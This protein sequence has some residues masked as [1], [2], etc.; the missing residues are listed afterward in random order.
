MLLPTRDQ[1]IH[2]ARIHQVGP[3]LLHVRDARQP[4]T[5]LQL[6]L[7]DLTELL[8]ALLPIAQ[9]VEE[10]PPDPDGRG[11]E[12]EGLEHVGAPRDAAVD[13][14]LAPAEDVR[15]DAVELQEG[16][17]GGLRRVEGAAAV[18]GQHEALDAVVPEGRFRVRGA[19]DPLDDDRQAGRL[20]DPG[21]V[22]PGERLVDVLAR[23]PA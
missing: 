5:R 4:H 14:D 10:G 19:L 22:G 12:G 7:Q 6:V 3:G 23:E 13:V 11:P 20:V 2:I 15:A 8:D 18:V 21:D 16:E 1:I 9:A 17:E